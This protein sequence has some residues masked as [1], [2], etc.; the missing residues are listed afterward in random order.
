MSLITKMR[1]QNAIYWPPAIPDDFGRPAH[2]AL[3]ELTLTGAGNFRVRWEDT[4]KE[5]LASSTLGLGGPPSLGDVAGT[6]I[7]SEALVYVPRLPDGSEVQVG[8]WLWLGDRTDLLD[9]ANPRANAEAHEVKR[10]DK[11]PNLK[12][13]ESLRTAYL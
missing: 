13:T 7:T 3:V 10:M 1:K 11:L 5:F 6:V 4:V 8:G 12:G 9:E 2:G